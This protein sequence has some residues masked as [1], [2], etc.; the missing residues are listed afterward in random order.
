MSR[1]PTT[2]VI[3]NTYNWPWALERALTG[4]ERQ[5]DRDFEVV[6]ADDGSGP[7]TRALLDRFLARGRFP[8]RHVWQRDVGFRRALALNRAVLQT[9]AELLCFLD[10]DTIPAADWVELYRRRCG[11]GEFAAGGY[12]RLTQEETRRVTIGSIEDGSFEALMTPERLRHVRFYHWANAWSRL[13]GRKNRP[14]LLGLS[15]AASRELF[16]KVNGLDLSYV[17]WG[18]EDSDLRTRMRMAG[19]IGRSVWNRSFAFH[20]WHPVNPTKERKAL[21]QARY[22]LLRAGGLPWRCENGLDQVTPEEPEAA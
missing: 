11:P 17:G 16:V 3:V 15:F 14:R 5:T 13:L 12:C 2:A 21:N 6:I 7:E 1:G 9:D 8:L 22:D 19:G 10:H 18:K 4:L 20:L